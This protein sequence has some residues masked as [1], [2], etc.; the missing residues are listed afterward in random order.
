MHSRRII[1]GLCAAVLLCGSSQPKVRP[2]EWAQPV[3][4]STL[5]NCYRV[6]ADLFRSEQ[7]GKGDIPDLKA[8]GVRSLINLTQVRGAAAAF[9][10]NGFHLVHQPMSAGSASVSDLVAVL[11]QLRAVEKPALVYCWHGSDR[12]GFIVAGYRMVFQDWTPETAIEELRLGGFGFHGSTY[13][14]IIRT[15]QEMDIAAVK[16]AVFE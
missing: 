6:S 15:L 1:A 7:P 12:T 16:K 9:E 8:L 14:N 4:G 2:V 11:R 5:E 3:I 10:Q 13:P